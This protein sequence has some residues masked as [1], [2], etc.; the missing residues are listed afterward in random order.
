MKPVVV[1]SSL[2]PMSIALLAGAVVPFQAA[3]NAALGKALGHPL[4]STLTSLTVSVLVVLPLLWI[5]RVPM[6]NF[7]IALKGP[8]WLWFGGI[9][10]VAYITAALILTPKIGVAN[11][12]VSVVAGQMLA[13]LFIDHVGIM[14]LEARPVSWE[15]L[16]GVALIVIGMLFVQ[17]SNILVSMNNK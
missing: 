7:S 5:M 13:S 1:L 16:I 9:A 15:R 8:L 17:M 2:I 14:G 10:G 4:W 6:P 12:M 11:F 3:S